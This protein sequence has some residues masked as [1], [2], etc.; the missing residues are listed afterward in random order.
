MNNPR[1]CPSRATFLTGQYSHNHGVLTNGP[2]LGGW[3]RLQGTSNWLPT[4]LQAAGYRTVHVGKFLNNYGLWNP[5]E[6][7][8]GW[9]EWYAMVDPTTYRYYGYTMNE[10][11]ALRAYGR[12]EDPA[13]TR[14]TSSRGAPSTPSSGWHPPSSRSSCRSP[15]SRRTRGALARPTIPSIWRRPQWLRAIVERSPSRGSLSRRAS[16]RLTSPTNP[17]RCSGRAWS[18]TWWPASRASTASGSSP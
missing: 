3:G 15:S 9:D 12:D 11:G 2:P 1:C 6:V 18:H 7:P 5:Y 13:G 14:P 10:N 8:A 16:T 4:W 17:R